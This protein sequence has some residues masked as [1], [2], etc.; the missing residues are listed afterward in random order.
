MRRAKALLG[1]HVKKSG[2]LRTKR[3][4]KKILNR[5]LEK[6]ETLPPMRRDPAL[7]TLNIPLP[8]P[9]TEPQPE[10]NF[11][12]CL[13]VRDETPELETVQMTVLP[14]RNIRFDVDEDSG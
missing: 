6:V 14:F 7:F 2:D 11:F 3:S 10:P 5:L 1:M 9:N 8:E 13:K 12:K 4:T